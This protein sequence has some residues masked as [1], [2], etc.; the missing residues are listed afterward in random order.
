M[1]LPRPLRS[2]KV[3]V[4]LLLVGLLVTGAGVY[5]K[6]LREDSSPA[7][8]NNQAAESQDSKEQPVTDPNTIRIIAT[9]DFIA[10]DAINAQAKRADGTYD[11]LQFMTDM[12]PAFEASDI[13]FCNQATLGGGT[14]YGISGYPVFN[15]P[16]EWTRD[17]ASL[18]CNVI[19]T[20]TNHTND[21]GQGPI[22]A[23]LNEWDEQ[24]NI[25]A[26]AGANRSA[27][28]QNMVRY[29]TVKGVKFAFLSYSTYVNSPNPNPYSLNR[30]SEP[31]VT[32]QM[33]EAR[34][35]SDII[36]VSMRWGTE[37]SPGINEAQNRDAAKLASLGAD[38]ILGHGPHVLEP[39]KMLP[40]KD[41]RETLVWFSLG[42]FLNAQLETEG[43]IGCLADVSI[44]VLT[45]KLTGTSCLPIYQH[46]E[47]TAEQ[48]AREDLL[49][50]KNFKLAPLE[51]AKDLLA[52]SQLDTTVEIQ[53]ERI[54][55]LINTYTKVSITSS[56]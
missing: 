41:G 4:P 33:T 15:A 31:L 6:F 7:S 36:I 52:D 12:Q 29:F 27:A 18:G 53:T 47:W 8:Q 17:M 32:S 30:F 43:L 22:T 44:D 46:Y 38:I 49:A 48:K 23:E 51:T 1:G 55:K 21:K 39:V 28:E 3:W 42:N 56:Q 34:A 50:R 54:N 45:K 13:R 10:H 26:V 16:L 5:V 24:E 25:L 14:A 9:G 19:N 2:K 35:K 20:G 11:Y 40:G 37:Y